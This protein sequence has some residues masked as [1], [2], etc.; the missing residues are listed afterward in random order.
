MAAVLGLAL[1]A[2][3]AWQRQLS[4]YEYRTLHGLKRVALP[5]LAARNPFG[6]GHW[7]HHKGGRD[8][9]EFI[10]TVGQSVRETV[11]TLQAGGGSLHVISSLKCRPPTHGDPLTAAHLVWTDGEMQTEAYLFQN[12][13]GTTDVYAHHEVSVTDPE[14]HL[15]AEQVNGDP[16]GVVHDALDTEATA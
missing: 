6:F 3:L 2:G 1:R 13:G 12:D 16:R 4:W 7:V 15:N 8:D 9:G 5:W 10:A 14:G 11:K